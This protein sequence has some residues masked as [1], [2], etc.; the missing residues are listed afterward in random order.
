[1]KTH[2]N[3]V[4]KFVTSIV[5]YSLI[6]ASCFADVPLRKEDSK[7]ILPEFFTTVK[8]KYEPLKKVASNKLIVDVYKER[9]ESRLKK[10]NK[11]IKMIQK[12]DKNFEKY[13]DMLSKENLV[14]A[15]KQKNEIQ[16]QIQSF[17]GSQLDKLAQTL[18]SNPRYEMFSVQY[19]TAFTIIEKRKALTEALFSDFDHLLSMSVKKIKGMS[20]TD[21]LRKLNAN[22]NLLQKEV[23]SANDKGIFDIFRTDKVW[24]QVLY[25]AAGV[26]LVS[27]LV[28]WSRYYGDYK[29]AKSK[30]EKEFNDFKDKLEADF[31]EYASTLE[32]K[33]LDYLSENGYIYT[34]CGSYERPD[35]IICN[36]YDYQLFTGTKY[37]TVM[38]YKNINT[39][40]ETL[41]SAAT[42]TSPF[43]PANCYDPSEYIEGYDIGYDFGYDDGMID[44]DDDGHDDGANDGD[45][46]GYDDGYWDG[47]DSGY[48]DGFDDGYWDYSKSLKINVIKK[49]Q[50]NPGYKRGFQ[51]GR[52]DGKLMQNLSIQVF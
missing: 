11:D 2:F 5:C 39:G 47:Y 43:I 12:S 17:S 8:E 6:S 3:Y 44:G 48:D 30:R 27:G 25:I 29:D 49:A 52:K 33:E 24:L 41:H 13:L 46:D 32:Q 26:A 23:S 50:N 20:K 21:L 22:K 35:S 37:C 9:Q 16:H 40:K 31:Q 45:N 34:Q 28:A 4:N 51:Q 38:C 36:G 19:D 7:K 1:M 14:Q 18:S 42:C 15:T 10:I